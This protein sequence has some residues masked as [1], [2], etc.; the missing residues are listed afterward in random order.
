MTWGSRAA[1]AAAVALSASTLLSA[2]AF[3]QD[4]A[5]QRVQLDEISIFATLNPIATFDYPGQVDIVDRDQIQ[6]EQASTVAETLKN[7]PGVFVNGGARMSGQTPNIRG[8]DGEDVL[9]LLD[10]VPQT[11]Q[12]GH[13]GRLFV[14]P[15]LLK[16]VEVVKGPN[17][18]LYGSGAL[19]GVIAM[20]T[21]DASDFLDAGETAGARV[22]VGFQT[23]D[24]QPILTTTGF[25]RTEDGKFETLGS[26]TY[27]R[28][29][30]IEL[31]NGD[32]LSNK[33]NIKSALAKGTAQVTPDL[34]A[35]A[36]WVHFADDGVTPA[37][38]QSNGEV[39]SSNA[40]VKRGIL[41][42]TVSGK[43]SYTPE[44]SQWFNGN[45]LAY[46]AQNKVTE[47]YYNSTRYQTRD[48]ETVGVKA[49]NRSWFELADWQTKVTFTYGVD[50]HKDKQKGA[51]SLPVGYQYGNTIS[52]IP[53]AEADYTGSF[54]QAEIK[55]LRP[56]SLPGEL[57]LTPSARFDAFSMEASGEEDFSDEAFSPKIAA[58]Y[59]PVPW[60][61]LF[62]NYGSAF[63]APDYNELYAMGNHFCMGPFCNTFVPN[64]DLK[65]QTAETGEVGAGF[66]FTDVA[67]KGDAVKL[68][69]SYWHMDAR[70]YINQEIVGAGVGGNSD[71]GCFTGQGGCYTR[72][73]NTDHAILSGA[74]IALTYD[75]ARFFGGVSW[76]TMTGRDA[77]TDEYVGAL[78]PDKVILTAGVKLPEYWTRVGT[79]FTFADEFTKGATRDAYN[80]VDLFAVIE[81]TE[82]PFKGL[83]VDLGI[84]NVTDEAYELVAADVYEKGINFKGAVSWTVKW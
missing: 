33:D 19:G 27:R 51:D 48:V 41:S 25:A 83:R 81:P 36:T 79:R 55:V 38:P 26:F 13:D 3:S 61:L 69:G 29:G 32:D 8:F 34:K 4:E 58:A 49:D 47:N 68:K 82:G 11:F 73:F 15:D 12:S 63:R 80:L 70:D 54:V 59:K 23:A 1:Y 24:G 62:G 75:S 45:F 35:T 10:G 18:S 43:L 78:Q 46:W 64:P 53:S 37:N 74:E 9:I 67:A 20:T 76:A 57:T 52:S 17:S 14:D 6:T 22:K 31:G 50:Y 56:A 71:M 66:E 72:F 44:G 30:S 42:D 5:G 84:D 60:F 77:D 2:S 21:V 40:L 28:M 16:R 39:S 65:P 7:V